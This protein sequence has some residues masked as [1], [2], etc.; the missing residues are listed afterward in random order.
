[1]Y[2]YRTFRPS[3]AWPLT[4][5]GVMREMRV[6]S[7]PVLAASRSSSFLW[8]PSNTCLAVGWARSR[9]DFPSLF[10]MAGS[11]PF[12]SRTVQAERL[13]QERELYV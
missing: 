12:C 4:L 13:I 1:M 5:M 3:S 10:L 2:M 7:L 9:G 6:S 11:A 8:L